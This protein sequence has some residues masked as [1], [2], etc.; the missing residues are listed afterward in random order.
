MVIR[1]VLILSR[2]MC[3][4]VGMMSSNVARLS[5]EIMI[6]RIDKHMAMIPCIFLKEDFSMGWEWD[7]FVDH[8]WFV[9]P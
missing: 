4:L 5:Y 6:G 8:N 7:S 2:N 9:V 3:G 1:D